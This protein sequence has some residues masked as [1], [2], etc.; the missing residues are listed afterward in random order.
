M[1]AKLKFAGIALTVA[2]MAG[3][4]AIGAGNGTQNSGFLADYSKLK[5]VDGV[6]GTLRYIDTSLN[7]KPYT[8]VIIDPV[9]IFTNPNPEYKG[10][11]PDA[12]KR[13]SD[14]FQNAFV[15]ALVGGYQVVNQPGPDVM[16]V[17]LAITGIQPTKPDLTATDFIP[18]KAIF[19]VARSAAGE[20]PQVAE[21]SAE[22][23]VLDPNGKVIGAA[24]STR[25][26]DKKVAQGEKITW[27]E[28][29][30]IVDVWAKN[31]RQHLDQARGF[32]AK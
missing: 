11:Q 8:K 29:Q 30:A 7:L 17:R 21:I 2:L 31:M 23:E 18:I 12:L 32:P 15:G 19:N 28:L 9:Q 26:G 13:M 6:D 1:N 25:K 27:K 3:G 4:S 14:A 5:P 20:A 10:L 16:R 24:V 22:I